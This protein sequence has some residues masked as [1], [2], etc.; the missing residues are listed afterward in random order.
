MSKLS[1]ET[2]QFTGTCKF[3]TK[4]INVNHGFFLSFS[5]FNIDDFRQSFASCA[6][7]L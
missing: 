6:F 1:L 5:F 2:S 7:A 4:N 3:F